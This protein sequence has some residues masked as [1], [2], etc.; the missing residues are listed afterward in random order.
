MILELWLSD[1]MCTNLYG[2]LLMHEMLIDLKFKI[3]CY[4][5]V[6]VVVDANYLSN[7]AKDLHV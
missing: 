4:S 1:D 5:C 2:V 3:S 6:K 7:R